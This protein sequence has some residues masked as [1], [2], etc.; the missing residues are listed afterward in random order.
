VRRDRA[1]AVARILALH[2][3]PRT[4]EHYDRAK[5]LGGLQVAARGI[6]RAVTAEASNGD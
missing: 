5:L 1:C 4:A 3:D 6:G 2:A